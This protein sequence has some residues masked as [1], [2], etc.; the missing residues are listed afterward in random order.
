MCCQVF[1]TSLLLFPRVP[2]LMLPYMNNN[3]LQTVEPEK[4]TQTYSIQC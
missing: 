2:S 3:L 4:K 1:L